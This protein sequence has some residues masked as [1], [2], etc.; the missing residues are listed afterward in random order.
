[1]EESESMPAPLTEEVIEKMAS[2]VDERASV[3]VEHRRYRGA[4]SPERLV[5]SVGE[6]L[7]AYVRANVR[8]GDRL[9]VW[10]YDE[11]CRDDN[12]IIQVKKPNSA[13]VVEPGGAY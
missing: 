9:L 6:M 12:A 1:M 13:G 5:F 10:N 11:L 7:G 4:S 3:I 8:S 2:F